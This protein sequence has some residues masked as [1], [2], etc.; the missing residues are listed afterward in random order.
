MKVFK[1]GY[2]GSFVVTSNPEDIVVIVAEVM[3]DIEVDEDI[4]IE[5]V[6][7]SQDEIDALEEFNGFD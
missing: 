2:Q 1:V 5:C 6:E 4:A 7:M 3:K